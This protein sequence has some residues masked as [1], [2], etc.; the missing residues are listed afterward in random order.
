MKDVINASVNII[1]GFVYY[2]D[3]TINVRG[4][5]VTRDLTV[6]ANVPA[7]NFNDF[8]QPGQAV[9]VR[10]LNNADAAT[11]NFT[12]ANKSVAN[13]N[14]GLFRTSNTPSNNLSA[15]RLKLKTTIDNQL[16]EVEGVLALFD[17]SYSWDVNEQKMQLK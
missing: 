8:V 9:F 17:P 10:K 2:W 15:L 4:G 16:Q 5:Y 11:L 1:K 13:A 12:E 7:S 3:P 6:N 14:A